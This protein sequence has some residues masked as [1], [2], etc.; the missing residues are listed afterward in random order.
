MNERQFWIIFQTWA[1]RLVLRVEQQACVTQFCLNVQSAT[2]LPGCH[3]I[4]NV[5]VRT[6]ALVVPGFPYTPVSLT[7][8]S[9]AMR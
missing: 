3:K 5:R 4:Q 1:R 9:E 7:G 2:L 6:Q 8:T